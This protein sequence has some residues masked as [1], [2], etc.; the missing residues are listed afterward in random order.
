MNEYPIAAPTGGD[1][2]STLGVVLIA[3]FLTPFMMSSLNVALPDIGRQFTLSAV[4]LSWVVTA[5][6]LTAA[7]FLLPAGRLADTRG[8]RLVFLAGMITFTLGMLLSA[9]APTAA[10]L[11]TGRVVTGVGSAM[12]FAT[13]N[14][15]IMTLCGP[16][17]RGRV[18]GRNVA[19]VYLG[20]SVGP[21]VG[22]MIAHEFGWRWIFVMATVISAGTS[23]VTALHLKEDRPPAGGAAFDLTGSLLLGLALTALLC[24]CSLLPALP[25]ALLLATGAAGMPLFLWWESRCANPI[26][27][28]ARFRRNRVFVFSNLAAL[29]NYAATAATSFLLC[30]YLQFIQGLTPK[31]TG[32]LLIAQPLVMTVFSPLA[33]RLSDRIEPGR[34]ASAG[35]A[36]SAAGLLALCGIGAGTPL[37]AVAAI[38]CA[39][40][41]GFALFSSPNTNA[42]MS[43]VGREHYGTASSTLATMRVTG[44]MASMA[45]VTL[46]EALHLGGRAIGPPTAGLFLHCLRTAF[47]IFFL[48]CVLGIFASAVRGR[49]RS[50]PSGGGG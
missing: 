25:G 11:V 5:H 29:I 38:L 15:I 24:G 39:M 43:S 34:L 13:G 19:A 47:V 8:R 21:L 9:V 6:V 48:L 4:A 46:L 36:V 22:G 45:V 31:Q 3:S 17:E 50:A 26:L 10:V 20:L 33:G 37:P 23:A 30:L 2:A 7:I 40:G 35:M 16:A 42:I 18:L 12:V 41:F 44:Q 14:A 28:V 49:T 32:F 27:D 1:R